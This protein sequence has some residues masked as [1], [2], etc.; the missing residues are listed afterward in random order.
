MRVILSNNYRNYSSPTNVNLSATRNTL[1]R[2]ESEGSLLS[3]LLFPYSELS[4]SSPRTNVVCNL[5]L[6]GARKS[7]ACNR[8]EVGSF[9]I[10]FH[11]FVPSSSRSSK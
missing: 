1:S 2:L 10:C 8:R 7:Q 4:E 6:E 9:K 5:H 3:L 11:I